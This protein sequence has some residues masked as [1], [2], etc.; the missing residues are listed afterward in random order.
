[1]HVRS[2]WKHFEHEH[3]HGVWHAPDLRILLCRERREARK[4]E[5]ERMAA[6]SG[7]A[8]LPAKFDSD[9]DSDSEQDANGSRNDDFMG[10]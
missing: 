5:A 6:E 1:M 3:G 8:V 4:A 9:S 10:R 7:G 2:M